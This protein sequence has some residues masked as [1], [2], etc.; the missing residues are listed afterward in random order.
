MKT[1]ILGLVVSIGGLAGGSWY[2]SETRQ[3]Q[4]AWNQRRAEWHT[5]CDVYIGKPVVS[6]DAQE[7]A[8]QLASMMEYIKD[9]CW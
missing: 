9:K 8:R 7:C 5:R 4:L 6:E 3:E 1:V 2:F